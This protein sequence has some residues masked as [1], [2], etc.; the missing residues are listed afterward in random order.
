LEKKQ[1]ETLN[2]W[3]RNEVESKGVLVGKRF[4]GLKGVCDRGL[5]RGKAIAI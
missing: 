2:F 1:A 5:K 4:I 3:V